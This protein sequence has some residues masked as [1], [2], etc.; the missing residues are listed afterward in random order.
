MGKYK[1][2][3]EEEIRLFLEENRQ[4]IVRRVEKKLRSK[5][6]AKTNEQKKLS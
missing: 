4:E 1:A 2:L 3:I 5:L 6:E